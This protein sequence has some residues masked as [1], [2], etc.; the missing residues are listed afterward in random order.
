MAYG[1]FKDIERLV[2]YVPIEISGGGI[3]KLSE[4]VDID[5]EFYFEDIDRIAVRLGILEIGKNTL[6]VRDIVRLL[7][8]FLKDASVINFVESPRKYLA[9]LGSGSG[10][11][12]KNLLFEFSLSALNGDTFDAKI[13]LMHSYHILGLRRN[14]VLLLSVIVNEYESLK[15]DPDVR[16][17]LTQFA[18]ISEPDNIDIHFNADETGFSKRYSNYL[19]ELQK[20]SH[21]YHRTNQYDLQSINS[22]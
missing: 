7:N 14:L 16:Q 10:V 5:T 2:E 22:R 9:L 11:P 6:K 15:Y 3:G 13:N 17:L 21:S 20:L 18:V 8:K 12:L 4:M 1:I 19:G